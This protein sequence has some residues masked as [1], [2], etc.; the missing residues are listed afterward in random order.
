MATPNDTQILDYLGWLN[1]YRDIRKTMTNR[2]AAFPMPAA[3]APK[4][5]AGKNPVNKKE[6][7]GARS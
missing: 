5:S 4:K 6:T 1:G 2:M 3:V 7:A